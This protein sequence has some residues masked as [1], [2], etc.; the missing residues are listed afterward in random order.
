MPPQHVFLVMAAAL[1]IS[2]RRHGVTS[3][4]AHADKHPMQMNSLPLAASS[5]WIGGT[6][7]LLIP[8]LRVAAQPTPIRF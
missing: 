2:C 1:W 7:A 5:A 8:A 3:P 4:E 6:C